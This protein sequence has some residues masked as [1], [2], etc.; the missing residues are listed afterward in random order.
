MF[1]S[2]IQNFSCIKV[3]Y[4]CFIN[5][6]WNVTHVATVSRVLCFSCWSGFVF[7]LP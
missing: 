4:F 5:F 7:L 6:H 1:F 3:S 2:G